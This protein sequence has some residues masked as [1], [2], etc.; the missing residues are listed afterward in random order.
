MKRTHALRKPKDDRPM[1]QARIAR[2][3]LAS[4]D[5]KLKSRGNITR[6]EFLLAAVVDFLDNCD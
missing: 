5:A 3:I 1:F 6:E 4:L 2:D